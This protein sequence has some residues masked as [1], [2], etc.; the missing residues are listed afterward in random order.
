MVSWSNVTDILATYY[1]RRNDFLLLSSFSNR[2]FFTKAISI[3]TSTDDLD[4]IWIVGSYFHYAGGFEPPQV[5]SVYPEFISKNIFCIQKSGHGQCFQ[6][7]PYNIPTSSLCG[8]G[9]VMNHSLEVQKIVWSYIDCWFG[10]CPRCFHWH[11]IVAFFRRHWISHQTLA[12]Q[13][14]C[15]LY[16]LENYQLSITVCIEQVYSTWVNSSGSNI[17]KKSSGICN[18]L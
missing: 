11:V 3:W 14:L 7:L 6:G 8:G 4:H 5:T 13:I 10:R 18:I 15:T 16:F 9:S 17:H 2:C 1:S 12:G